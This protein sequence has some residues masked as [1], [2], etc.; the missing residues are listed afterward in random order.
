MLI[1]LINVNFGYADELK[2]HIYTVHQNIKVYQCQY[3]DKYFRK[4]GAL[5]I[6][7]RAIH[8]DIKLYKCQKCEKEFASKGNLNSHMKTNHKNP[9]AKKKFK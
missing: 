9:L 3:C 7:K 4:S 1:Q 8:E 5:L 2:S 6:H